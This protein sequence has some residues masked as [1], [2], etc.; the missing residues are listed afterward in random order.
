MRQEDLS[1]LRP[2]QDA[3]RSSGS[4]YTVG[5]ASSESEIEEAQS[6]RFR[7]FAGELGARLAPAA[8]QIGL[9]RD[10]FDDFC[11]HLIVRDQAS[12]AVVGTYRILTPASAQAAGGYYSE[13]EFD[14]T[15]LAN[16]RDELVEVGRSCVDPAHRAGGAMTLLWSGLTDFMRNRGHRYLAGCASI[17]LADGGAAAAGVYKSLCDNHRAPDEWRVTPHHPARLL[18]RLGAVPACPPSRLPP[19]IKGYT[20]VGA[21]ICGEPAW[22]AD[23]NTADLFLLL[24][25]DKMNPRYSQHF[26]RRR[27]AVLAG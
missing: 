4:R 25:L 15:A 10:R 24:P 1:H 23:F 3:E 5:L 11:E 16:I 14:M 6:L 8:A 18:E 17:S 27:P 13:T 12:D 21:Y 9:D 7:V 20:R 2:A 22:D 19:L 26:M